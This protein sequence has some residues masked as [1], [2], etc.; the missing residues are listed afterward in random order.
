MQ[1]FSHFLIQDSDSDIADEAAPRVNEPTNAADGS[2][3]GSAVHECASNDTLH[4]L[5]RNA[6][7]E[8]PAATQPAAPPAAPPLEH[9]MD[10]D[11]PPTSSPNPLPPT[12]PDPHRLDGSAAYQTSLLPS[13]HQHASASAAARGA[14]SSQQRDAADA[15]A[16]DSVRSVHASNVPPHADEVVAPPTQKKASACCRLFSFC[17]RGKACACCRLFSICKRKK[18]STAA[19]RG[20]EAQSA[21]ASAEE[22]TSIEAQDSPAR[23]VAA[24]ATE[25]SSERALSIPVAE[26]AASPEHSSAQSSKT[27]CAQSKEEEEVKGEEASLQ[28]SRHGSSADAF[29]GHS[30]PDA[31]EDGGASKN[32]T[33][34]V[35]YVS[36]GPDAV[37]KEPDDPAT[38]AAGSGDAE[39]PAT[40]GRH[41]KR[42]KAVVRRRRSKLA[43]GNGDSAG[44]AG[45]DKASDISEDEQR[46]A[47]S[48]EARVAKASATPSVPLDREK[49]PS[50]AT[51]S[52]SSFKAKPPSP[53]SHATVAAPDSPTH[54]GS[55]SYK[56]SGSYSYS[57]GYS[58][59]YSASNS[60]AASRTASSSIGS[61]QKPVASDAPRRRSA[62]ASSAR[63]I[64]R[65]AHVASSA[66]KRSPMPTSILLQEEELP[67]SMP[68]YRR[69]VLL[70]LRARERRDAEEAARE[71]RDLTFRPQIHNP[72]N[73][74]LDTSPAVTTDRSHS[75]FSESHGFPGYSSASGFSE[76]SPGRYRIRR[77]SPRLL[78]S[79]RAPQQPAPPPFKPVISEYAKNSVRPKLNVFTRLY[80][81]RSSSPPAPGGTYPHKPEISKLACELYTRRRS[82]GDDATPP[83]RSVFD[84]LYNVRRSPSSSPTKSPSRSAMRR[85]SF[86]PQITERARRLSA[87]L[88]KV[89]FGERLYRNSLSP[90]RENHSPF[91]AREQFRG[92][93]GTEQVMTNDRSKDR[94]SWSSQSS[95]AVRVTATASTDLDRRL[96]QTQ[97]TLEEM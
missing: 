89:P 51:P 34:P 52:A 3:H 63:S 59:S 53:H 10:R 25:G 64:V 62:Q 4:S 39:K 45:S 37:H 68:A 11:G 50:A 83:R 9:T 95:I 14:P 48:A 40:K 76:P 8:A 38:A 55:A 82:E 65:S 73:N 29:A 43:N 72:Y 81:P 33:L 17:K 85:P 1:R 26:G 16:H 32:N 67:L 77:V 47:H 31:A 27:N 71:W 60:L 84:R 24:R 42:V 28:R 93:Y 20:N 54:T 86:K 30:A 13:S 23:F 44:S 5:P 22:T 96:S 7:N 57:Y 12:S 2:S 6:E 41:V 49:M 87:M 90:R 80:K 74:C 66:T 46:S 58:S 15:E 94:C 36:Q 56:G 19:V 69:R 92:D 79:R 97:A 88:P 35:P 18:T 75:P 70:D 91:R 21:Q 61:A 78:Q